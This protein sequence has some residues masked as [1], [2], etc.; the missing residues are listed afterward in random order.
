MPSRSIALLAVLLIVGAVGHGRAIAAS[1]SDGAAIYAQH[2][3]QCHGADRLGGTGPA[4]LPESL[5]RLRPAAAR[6]VIRDGRTAT[7]MPAFGDLL[8]GAAIDAVA[9][10]IH[11]P[12]RISPIWGRSEI[13]TSHIAEPSAGQ[14]VDRP[15]FAAD[16]LNLFV[17]VESGDHHI[18][19]LDGDRFEPIHRFPT[20]YA[21][22]GG[23]K[24]SP[25]G[26]YVYLAS[27]DGWIA[28]YDLYALALVA[29]IRAGINTRNLALSGDGRF[30]AVANY[31]PHT[32]VL[33]DARDLAL[34]D[35]LK[36]EDARRT[37]TSRVSAVYQARPRKSFI[38]ALKDIAEIWEIS[39][40]ETARPVYPGLVHSHEQGAVEAVGARRGLFALRRI[41]IDQPLDDF[42]FDE[43]YR[44]L[45]GSS[46]ET[47]RTAVVNLN[48]GRQIGW[49]ELDGLPHLASGITWTQGG[50]RVMA[51]PHLSRGEISV[52]DTSDWRLVGSVKLP[53]PGFFLRSHEATPYA[54]TDSMLGKQRDG[55]HI[56]DKRSLTLVRTLTPAPG[57]TAAHV[58]F[59]R[60]GRHALVSVW[61]MDGAL[62]V[63]DAQTFAEVKRLPMVRP[64]GKYNVFNKISL[65][66]G[67]SH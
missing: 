12:T 62:I 61:D 35:V 14:G 18:T 50:R 44:H 46:R 20:R 57:R 2:C 45:L 27:R 63:Y 23:P 29:E 49:V 32:L 22:H 48:V 3:A 47:G 53:G 65:S 13:E 58:E 66:E 33:L 25:D 37:R 1:A 43:S 52:F 15:V 5:E 16:P 60:D 34:I 30:V 24:F 56:I 10:L 55:I 31:L 9:D 51:T 19:L 17:V 39:T 6:V 28:K 64:S 36:V 38:L 67:T 11:A 4:L 21:L 41:A 26:R 40:D 7:Q 8:D 42:Q 59:T 54:W